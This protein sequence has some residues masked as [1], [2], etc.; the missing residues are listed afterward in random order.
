MLSVAARATGVVNVEA[1]GVGSVGDVTV[2]VLT[3]VA[4]V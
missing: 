2:A 3:I 4:L 1:S